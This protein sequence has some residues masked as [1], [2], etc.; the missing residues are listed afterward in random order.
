MKTVSS[1]TL[2]FALILTAVMS[3]QAQNAASQARGDAHGNYEFEAHRVQTHQMHARDYAEIV[4]QQSQIKTPLPPEEA[5][6]Y[7][8]SV[9]QSI[10]SANKALDKLQ[11]AH[12]KDEA[13]QKSAENI[14]KFHKSALAHCD[15]CESACKK[16]AEGNKTVVAKCCADMVKDLDAAQAETG[17]LMKHLKIEKISLLTK[18]H[19]GSAAPKKS[20]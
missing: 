19:T 2:G 13:V 5:V 1:L 7:V 3:A 4:F 20:E 8:G 17:K 12:P 14:K 16:P 9:K 10:A 6:E 18:N 15:M 11:A